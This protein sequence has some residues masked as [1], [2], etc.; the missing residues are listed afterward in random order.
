MIL[1]KYLHQ[2]E[3]F[4]ADNSPAVLTGVG[5]VGT[6]TCAYLTGKATFK[7]AALISA[8]EMEIWQ[9]TP[10]DSPK[11]P[12]LELKKK[13]LLVWKEYIPAVSTGAL[14]VAAII[15]ANRISTRR[16]AAMAAAYSLSEKSIKEYK[17]KVQEKL[18]I[19][20]EQ[21]VKDSVAQDKVDAQPS[22]DGTVILTGN[23]DVLCFD[24]PCERYFKSNVES[25]R[26]V[27]NDINQ[28][29]CNTG[30]ATLSDFYVALKLGTTPYSEELGW[31]TDKL[32]ELNF[33][34]TMSDDNQ[35]CI[36]IDYAA[37][38]IRGYNHLG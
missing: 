19:K 22:K 26:T 13:F 15:S 32:L 29:V 31:T 35:P 27:V 10:G 6:V 2:T 17:E 30:Q 18:G 9:M 14:T 20:K 16:A 37:T 1:S 3:R 24:Q 28:Q 21:E 25:I 12:E 34:T 33:S 5:V 11:Y 38:P 36:C 4:V 23:G 7:A 8:E